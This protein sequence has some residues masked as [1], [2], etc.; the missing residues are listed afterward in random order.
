MTDTAPATHEQARVLTDRIKTA[1]ED[2]WQLICEAYTSRAWSAL[3]YDNWDGYCAAEFGQTRLRLPREDRQD[4]VASL[5]DHGLST[6]AIAAATGADQKTVWNDLEDLAAAGEEFS[7]PVTGTDGKTYSAGRPAA[8][9]PRTGPDVLDEDDEEA[10]AD[11]GGVDESVPAEREKAKQRRP[12]PESFSDANRDLGRAADRLA[13]IAE[14]DRFPHNRSQT[15]QQVPELLTALQHTTQLVLAM[16]LPSSGAG[17]E[18]RRW[19]AASLHEISDALAGVANSLT[20]E[21]K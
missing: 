6:R 4:V 10:V 17:K 5:R 11:A 1:V 16:D 3:G 7:S 9:R 13:R 2:I 14:D 19:W 15:H 18:A 12:L 8:Q 21:Q 20:T